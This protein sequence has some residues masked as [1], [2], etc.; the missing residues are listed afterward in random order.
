MRLFVPPPL[1]VPL[2]IEST[3]AGVALKRGELVIAQAW[4]H[5][6][7]I[8]VPPRPSLDESRAMSQNYQGFAEHAFSTCFVCGPDRKAGDGLRIFP[9]WSREWK[10]VSAPWKPEPSLC[11]AHGMVQPWFVWS[12]LD[13]PGGWSFL[14]AG[15]IAAVLGE[16]A[17]RIDAPVPGRDELIVVGWELERAG[18]KHHTGSALLNQHGEVL[19]V[20]KGTWFEVDPGQ[21][22]SA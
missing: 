22:K 20:G 14:R 1:D 4:P 18:R 3:D 21:L 11:D 2:S 10:L 16:Y 7:D 15:G 17:V 5:D 12:A 8:A 6:L 9:G 19:A 13:C